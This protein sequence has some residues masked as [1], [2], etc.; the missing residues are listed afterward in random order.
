M[1]RVW[2]KEQEW[3]QWI[4][5]GGGFTTHRV[6]NISLKNIGKLFEKVNLILI[7]RLLLLVITLQNLTM[8][9]Y[10]LMI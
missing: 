5:P 10:K 7:I 3:R 4:T 9:T 2:S 8:N 1:V 6:V